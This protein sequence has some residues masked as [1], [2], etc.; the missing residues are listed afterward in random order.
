MRVYFCFFHCCFF[1]IVVTLKCILCLSSQPKLFEI[2]VGCNV[3]A[4]QQTRKLR[5]RQNYCMF[6]NILLVSQHCQKYQ[7]VFIPHVE[8]INI[9]SVLLLGNTRSFSHRRK[10]D[11]IQ[12][13]YGSKKGYLRIQ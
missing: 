6:F 9:L 10:G 12:Q 1:M 4:K 13:R 3:R 7:Q 8:K 5:K 2:F 11:F